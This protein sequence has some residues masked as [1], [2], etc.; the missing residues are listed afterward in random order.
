MYSKPSSEGRT[1]ASHEKSDIAE[2][3]YHFWMIQQFPL[4][5]P[6]GPM[7]VVEAEPGAPSFPDPYRDSRNHSAVVPTI[8]LK[9]GAD[10]LD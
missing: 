10:A 6:I 2:V 4:I 9:L 1:T 3:N 5:H 7:T 8:A